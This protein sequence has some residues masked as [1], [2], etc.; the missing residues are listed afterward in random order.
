[1]KS[2][3]T[4]LTVFIA[5]LPVNLPAAD[6]LVDHVE[7]IRA[8]G[9]AQQMSLFFPGCD[10]QGTY[11]L[12]MKNGQ[13]DAHRATAGNVSVNGVELVS[14]ADFTQSPVPAVITRTIGNIAERNT[15]AIS[16]TAP[17]GSVIGWQV[18]AE[19]NCPD[20]TIVSPIAGEAFNRGEIIVTG[21]VRQRT[22]EVGVIVNGVLAQVNGND[23][24]ANGVALAAGSNTV[25]ATAIFEDGTT[26]EAIVVITNQDPY[27]PQITLDTVVGSGIAS[28]LP[29]TQLT[30]HFKVED[31]TRR[32]LVN[33]RVDYEGDGTFDLE[34][35][36]LDSFEHVYPQEGLF[37]LKVVARDEL[38]TEYS[39]SYMV[40]V[41]PLPPIKS[42]WEKM[43]AALAVRDID[44]AVTY[45]RDKDKQREIYTFIDQQAQLHPE[46]ASL[47]QVA[48]DMT[49][50]QLIEL[51][52]DTAE[53]RIR[54]EEPVQGVMTTITYYVH[55]TKSPVGFWRL[56]RL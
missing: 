16:A 10:T 52:G 2:T 1:M 44:G 32:T 40:N 19:V 50:I 35:P 8:T 12:T 23:W 9:V 37:P 55:F 20:I 27:A 28:L 21:K 54:R 47:S 22:P 36:S 7:Y 46:R 56:E 51:Q 49:D 25:K 34:V 29:A 33:Y 39:A 38:G 14:A 45:F 24:A 42:K 5:L 4:A 18:T 26:A 15:I 3:L 48:G 41:H 43:K 53:Y 17:Q 13:D 6:L 11:T 31:R 30:V